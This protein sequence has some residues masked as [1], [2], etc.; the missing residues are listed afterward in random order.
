MV[1]GV[2]PVPAFGEWPSGLYFS[3]GSGGEYGSVPCLRRCGVGIARLCGASGEQ[4]GVDSCPPS[5]PGGGGEKADGRPPLDEGRPFV[6]GRPPPALDFGVFLPLPGVRQSVPRAELFCVIV[7]VWLVKVGAWVMVVSDSDITV[8]GIKGR[9]SEGENMDLWA[10]LWSLV[11]ERRVSIEAR[12]VKAHAADSRDLWVKYDPCPRDV[13]GNE[14]ADALA[15]RGAVSHA[16]PAATA[17]VALEQIRLCGL[18]QGRLIAILGH[19][20]KKNPRV[21]AHAGVAANYAYRFSRAVLESR[22]TPWVSR[23][24]VSCGACGEFVAG[25]LRVPR[26]QEWLATSC[27]PLAPLGAV[28]PTRVWPVA[29]EALYACGKVLHGSHVL[30]FF[31]GLYACTVCGGVAGHRV[32]SLAEPCRGYL[33]ASA[34]RSIGRLQA[35]LL[36]YGTPAWPDSAAGWGGRL[37]A[38][39]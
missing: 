31:R 18:V 26:V 8:K 29:G 30:V 6:D 13:V 7:L 14:A 36:P 16:V 1:Q 33:T 19:L 5:S 9:R 21:K 32:K 35:G 28:V 12:W 23:T 27:S 17:R 2:G 24:G 38:L 15:E 37:F 20:T 25:H 3:D 34:K 22:H 4:D 39:G 10:L 11:A